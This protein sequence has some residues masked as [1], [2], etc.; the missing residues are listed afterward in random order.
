[1][2]VHSTPPHQMS[3]S[4]SSQTA[5]R[6]GWSAARARAASAPWGRGTVAVRDP[7]LPMKSSNLVSVRGRTSIRRSVRRS[8]KRAR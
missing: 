3:P 2:Q 4:R 1:M 6:P 5:V 7:G 8:Q